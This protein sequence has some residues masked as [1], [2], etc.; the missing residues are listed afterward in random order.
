MG[1]LSLITF[2]P[3]IGGVVI[4]LTPKEK[5][6][7]VRAI[8]VACSATAFLVSLWLWANFNSSIADFQ[9]VEN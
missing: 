3:L 7:V 5:V 9:F 1:V 8:A 6:Q 4:L 2:L